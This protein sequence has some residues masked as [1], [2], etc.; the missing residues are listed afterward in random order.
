M[1]NLKYRKL[2]LQENWQENKFIMVKYDVET[3]EFN[4]CV[5]E[6]KMTIDYQRIHPLVLDGTAY[7]ITHNKLCVGYNLSENNNVF[8]PIFSNKRQ[9]ILNK[10]NKNIINPLKFWNKVKTNYFIILYNN[11]KIPIECIN[12]IIQFIYQ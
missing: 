2:Y 10:V 9:R 7:W 4:H 5:K 11:K 8:R 1:D 6:S 3:C 12:Y